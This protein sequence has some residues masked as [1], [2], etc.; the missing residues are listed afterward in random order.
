MMCDKI[1]FEVDNWS[2]F[3]MIM[4]VMEELDRP[5]VLEKFTGNP[6]EHRSSF[7]Q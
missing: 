2:I 5:K 3:K 6:K 1:N 4:L 7:P